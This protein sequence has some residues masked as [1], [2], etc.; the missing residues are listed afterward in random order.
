MWQS[1]LISAHT[2]TRPIYLENLHRKHPVLRTG[3]NSLSYGDVRAI[4]S[5]NGHNAPCTKDGAYVTTAGSHYHLAN[6]TD[7]HDHTRKR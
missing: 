5:M 2:G 3:P 4:K 1:F 6:V 7:K